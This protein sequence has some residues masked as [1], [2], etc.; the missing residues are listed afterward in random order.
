MPEHT[1]PESLIDQIRSGRAVLVVGAGI[2]V[3]SW[4][5][6]LETM[7]RELESRGREGDDAAARD[8][9]KLL[10]KGSLV[11]ALGFLARSLG[12]DACDRI[13]A[14]LWQTPELPPLARLVAELPFHHVW[15]TFPGDLLERAM[16]AGSPEGWPPAKV[17]TYR[18]LGEL[19]SRRRT[20]VKLLG[21]FDHYVVAPG[22]VRRALSR[23]V[24]LRN[25]AREAYVEGTLVFVGFRF[26]DPDLAALLD[27][28][29][30]SF[31]PPRGTHYLI[32]AGLGPVAVDELMAEHHIEVIAVGGRVPEA[33]GE[34]ESE[35]PPSQNQGQNQKKGKK[36]KATVKPGPAP[37]GGQIDADRAAVDW[38]T[39]LRDACQAAGLSLE[40]TR[41]AADDLDG[42]LALL[43]DEL[44]EARDAVDL[45]ERRAREAGDTERVVEVLLARVDQASEAADRAALLLRLA[46]AYEA[47][48]DATSALTALTTAWHVDPTG[49]EAVTAA[50]RLAA[51]RGDW[52]ELVA[53]AS[54]LVTELTGATA[55]LWWGR[56]G[57]WYAERVD[58][59]DYAATSLRRAIELDAGNRDAH[60]ALASLLRAQQKWAELADT[61]RAHAAIEPDDGVKIDLLLALGDLSESQLAATARAIEAYQEVLELDDEND[62]GLGALERL[63]RKGERWANLARILDRRAELAAAVGDGTGAAALRRELATLRAD[64]LGDLEGAIGRYEAAL[65][66]DP[67]D[68]VAL[69]ALQDLYDKTG[70]TEDF[71]RTVERVAEVAPEAE[72]LAAL[73]TLASALEDRPGAEARAITAHEQ[74]LV[75]D[76]A[77]EDAYRGLARLHRATGQLYELVAVLDRHVAASRTPAQKVE[78]LLATAEVHESELSDPHRAIESHLAALAIDDACVASWTALARLYRRTEAWDRAVG[79]IARH[80]GLDAGAR[81]SL[82]A[83]AGRI[84]LDALGDAELAERHLEE[85]LRTDPEHADALRT[86]AQVHLGRGSAQLGLD[87]LLRAEAA[88]TAR[89]ARLDLLV[90]AAELAAGPLDDDERAQELWQ[91]VLRVDPDHVPAGRV[92]A[93]H[94]VAAQRWDDALPVLEM[95]ARHADVGDRAERAR[96][97][98]QLGRA[99]AELHRTE[100]ATRH[101]RLAVE[102]DPDDLDATLGLASTLMTEAQALD[103]THGDASALWQEVDRRYREALARHGSGLADG[104]VAD[105]WYRL[106]LAA[107]ALGDDKK[108]E[109]ALRR[110]LERDPLHAATLQALVEVAGQRGDWKIVVEAK[111]S[112]LERAPDPI[113]VKLLEEIGDILRGK[114]KDPGTAAGAYL[115]AL[116]LTPGSHVLLHK[117]LDAHTEQ[118]QWRR[119]IDALD[120]LAGLEASGERRARYQYA[121]AVIARD[122]IADADLAVERFSAALDAQPDTPKAFEAIDRLL[123]D[124]GEWKALARAYRRMLKRVG[125]AAPP[126]RLLELWTRLGDICLDHLGDTEAAIAAFEVAA[127][128][129]PEELARREQLAELYLEAGE[130]RRA[131]AIEELQSLLTQGPD[132]VELY[133]ALAGLY[134]AEHEL[135]K[136]WCLAQA[137]VFLG[138]A[139]DDERALYERHRAEHFSPA[140]RRLTEELWQKSIMHPREDRHVG[141][142]FASTLGALAAGSAQPPQAFGL[143]ASQRADLERDGRAATRVARYAAGVLALDPVPM[144]WL[145]EAGDGLR[146]ANTTVAVAGAERGRLV[147][148][149]LV[150]GPYLAK[151]DERELAFELGKRMAYLRPERYVNVALPAL[152]TLEGAFY[153]ALRVA[154]AEVGGEDARRHALALE[155][156]LAAPVREQVAALSA[157]IRGRLGNGLVSG[158][159]SAADLTAN[160]V[161]FILCNDLE[162]AARAIATETAA[163]SGLP[164]KDRLRDLLAYSVSESYFQVR[165]HLGIHVREE[166]AA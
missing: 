43:A 145:D 17:V 1:I 62:D 109:T 115:E 71:L 77:A 147:P 111:R 105:L 23:A 107:R 67:G 122:E 102:A 80:A 49:A 58:R 166:A 34:A 146:F 110:A 52:S 25:Y 153:G 151:T 59:P 164:V 108:A 134:R 18:A 82:L 79:A 2:G 88:Q 155:G 44:P 161:G 125:D 113:K 8:L 92:V 50:E 94:L 149:I 126:E 76:P 128:L 6:L 136:A 45:I 35:E 24:D 39:E 84:A 100:K 19:A 65:S 154:G 15:T 93:E 118:K 69:A 75:I 73:R 29:F 129:A 38:V 112:Q 91:R 12:D 89:Q 14:E 83:E 63:Y 28:V 33:E 86:L 87:V 13:I 21:D 120:E 114:L 95:L 78:L 141:A 133:K 7:T 74:V 106:G 27:R 10:H 103:G 131:D 165:R 140:S 135:D 55:S 99:Y 36:R 137:L 64:K 54:E 31:E 104:Q 42:W 46:A 53:E 22:S 32:G 41:P 143:E 160:R 162:V 70:R 123:T 116:D 139:T 66:T 121:A 81:A 61:L 3:P 142:I 119:A 56:M 96:R 48:G 148:S 132:R 90:Q 101:Y 150:G 163:M 11:R 117:L 156:Q 127:D 37:A 124:R 4:K 72:R 16:A 30:G 60:C 138:A 5:Q 9:G 159:R 26:G 57:R 68:R 20:L 98:A 144:V 40:Q 97:E 85:A 47:A 152:P 157:K 51:A 158:W 130:P